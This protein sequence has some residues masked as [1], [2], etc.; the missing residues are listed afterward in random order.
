VKEKQSRPVKT[1]T[2]KHLGSSVLIETEYMLPYSLNAILATVFH[3]LRKRK[4]DRL[5]R[6][7]QMFQFFYDKTIREEQ[8]KADKKAGR[9][10]PKEEGPEPD[11][12]EFWR[13]LVETPPGHL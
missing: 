2:I 7:M 6:L 12:F 5:D 8:A 11:T 4:P 13:E 9:K 3:E 10:P 1:Y